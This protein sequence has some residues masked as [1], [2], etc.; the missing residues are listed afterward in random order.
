MD[1]V[2]VARALLPELKNYKLHT[3]AKQLNVSLE[4]HH[5]AVDD[6]EATAE[7]FLHMIKRLEDKEIK[8]L[9]QLNE[10]CIPNEESIRKMPSY[11]AV[12]LAKNETGRVN[13]YR[14]VSES[15]LK[16]FN[17]R[18]KLPKSLFMKWREGLLIGSA[19]EAG[20]LFRALVEEKPEEEIDRLVR[21]YD[22]L[23]I[24]PIGNNE[25]MVRD[26]D[27]YPQI[28]DDND[29]KE[30]NRR[31]VS[32]GEAYNKLVVATCDV[33]FLNPED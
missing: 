18:P 13:L 15:H 7:I 2:S 21:F 26:E 4:H 11:H 31:I 20:E 32:L 29:L 10:A 8:N 24:Q 16:Y 27:K 12:I 22:Y 33:H 17:R 3:V 19:C 30:L 6:A 23:E 5:R 25:F 28:Q 1:T 9:T 14:L